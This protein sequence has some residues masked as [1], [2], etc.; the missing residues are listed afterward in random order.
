[1][2][3]EE[4]AQNFV[5]QFDKLNNDNKSRCLNEIARVFSVKYDLNLGF[6]LSSH[7]DGLLDEYFIIP[8]HNTT[9]TFTW[10]EDMSNLEWEVFG[11]NDK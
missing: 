11:V 3:P 5:R 6:C 7:T 8:L 2:I 1:M 4:L 10:D 9:V